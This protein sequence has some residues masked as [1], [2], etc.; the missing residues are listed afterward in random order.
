MMWVRVIEADIVENPRCPVEPALKRLTGH[1]WSVGVNCAERCVEVAEGYDTVF[2]TEVIDM[3][4]SAYDY[5][6]DAAAGRAIAPI[7]FEVG[8]PRFLE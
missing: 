7:E 3:P 2:K 1:E 6:A 8:E 4:E 5:I